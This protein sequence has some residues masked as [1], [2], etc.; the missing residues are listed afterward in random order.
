L[1]L[2]PTALRRRIDSGIMLYQFVADFSGERNGTIAFSNLI[3]D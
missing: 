1:I 3:A 2:K